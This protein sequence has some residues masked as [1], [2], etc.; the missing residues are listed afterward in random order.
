[1]AQPGAVMRTESLPSPK[2]RLVGKLLT[3][4]TSMC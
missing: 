1:M 4:F 3:G 2:K